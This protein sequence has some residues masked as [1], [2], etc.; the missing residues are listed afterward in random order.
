[1]ARLVP[2]KKQYTQKA[3]STLE[4]IGCSISELRAHI[5]AQFK[6]G[7]TWANHGKWHIDHIRPCASFNLTDPEQQ[8][9][10]FNYKNLQPLWAE[11]NLRKSDKWVA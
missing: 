3:K 1:M 4:L 11:E 2:K 7:M 6:P 5:E 8:R 10:C 9:Q